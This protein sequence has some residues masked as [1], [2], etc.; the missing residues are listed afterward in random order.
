MNYKIRKAISTDMETI[1]KIGRNMVDKYERTHLG[2]EMANGYIE[3]GGC[4]SDFRKY[5]DDTAVLLL[6]EKII[7]LIIWVEN[8]IQGFLIDIPYWGTGA[9]QY[10]LNETMN[11][12]FNIYDKITLE[13]FETS[14]RANSYY[15]KVGFMKAGY[16]ED[17]MA[18]RIIYKKTKEAYHGEKR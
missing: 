16:I 3:S 5:F 7:G 13:C 11:E 18:N 15:Q 17:E 4:D 8:V 1:L 2:D 9:A 6:N 12:K 10:L 14:P